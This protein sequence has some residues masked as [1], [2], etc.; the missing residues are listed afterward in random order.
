M[1]KEHATSRRCW[2]TQKIPLLNQL[3]S[4]AVSFLCIRLSSALTSVTG[5]LSQWMAL[6]SVFRFWVKKMFKLQPDDG[7]TPDVC[8]KTYVRN[9]ALSDLVL[10]RKIDLS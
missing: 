3:N 1:P 10:V 8:I 7:R 4:G 9:F 6:S 5:F 2:L